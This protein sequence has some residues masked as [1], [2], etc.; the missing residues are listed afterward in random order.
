MFIEA[1]TPG[2]LEFIARASFPELPGSLLTR[3]VAFT[4]RIARETGE[5]RTWG[6]RGG[7]W[8]LNLRDLA[9]WATAARLT[10]HCRLGADAAAALVYVSRM[11]TPEDREQVRSLSECREVVLLTLQR[12]CR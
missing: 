2:D 1:L 5:L 12:I 10:D 11:R 8:D 4:C 6:A 3:M 7:P 9:R